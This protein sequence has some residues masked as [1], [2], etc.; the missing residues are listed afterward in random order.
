MHSLQPCQLEN[1]SLLNM[2]LYP[3]LDMPGVASLCHGMRTVF[4][5]TP[6]PA[7]KMFAGMRIPDIS[8]SAEGSEP[9]MCQ[10]WPGLHNYLWQNLYILPLVQA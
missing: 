6:L 1:D 3:H 2:V 9:T 7:R 8:L 5:T 10:Q 4:G